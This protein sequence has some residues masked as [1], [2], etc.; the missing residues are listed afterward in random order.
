M[1]I[2][3]IV[4]SFFDTTGVRLQTLRPCWFYSHLFSVVCYGLFTELFG[5]ALYQIQLPVNNHC[6]WCL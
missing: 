2:L 4:F 1:Y 6:G 3:K 5:S